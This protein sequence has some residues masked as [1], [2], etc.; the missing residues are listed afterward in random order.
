MIRPKTPLEPE[1]VEVKGGFFIMGCDEGSDDEKPAHEVW[2][3]PFCIAVYTV[4]NHD[5]EIFLKATRYPVTP[6][7]LKDPDFSHPMQPVTGTSWHDAAAFCEWL[8]DMSRRQYRLPT[9]AE[10][11]FA[12]TAGKRENTYPWGKRDW[13]QRSDLHMR[14]QNGPELV[15]SFEANALGI[16]D[17]GINV[18]EWCA[19]WYDNRYY[20][21]S[22][23]WNPKGA[24]DGTRKASRGGSW[25][26]QIKITR[27]S[28]R[29]SLPPGMRYAD[30]GFRVA[31][32]V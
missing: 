24:Q 4:T 1:M 5:Y 28:A 8:S 2:V 29:S 9:E 18:H 14:F 15:G 11:E 3:D 30:Y 27:C 7:F 21:H 20:T 6:P 13:E 26:H 17:M 16:H 19:D 12:A 25:R 31:C 32:N 23:A 10:W 22:T